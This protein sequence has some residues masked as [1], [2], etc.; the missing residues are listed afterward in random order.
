MSNSSNRSKEYETVHHITSRIAHKVRFLQEEAERNDLIEMIRRA[1]DFTGVKLLGWCIMINHFHILVFLPAPVKVDE[2]EIVRR[3]GVL[4]GAKCA[5]AFEEQLAKL[6]L[7]GEDGCKEVE[8]LLDVQR[9]RM[10]S[11]GEFVKIV[12]QWFSEEYNRRN[13][14][15]GTLW[16]GAYHDRMV[17]CCHK[18]MAACLRYIHLNPIRAAA[19][20][21][22]DGYSWS[23]YSAFKKGDEVAIDGMRFVYS[24]KTEDGQEMSLGEIAEMHEE[25]LANLLEKWKL[26]RAEEIVLNRAAGYEMPDDPLTN[27]AILNQARVHLEEVR[28]ASMDL[29]AQREGEKSA[30]LQRRKLMDE[31]RNLLTLRPGIDTVAMEQALGVPRPSLYRYL[32]KMR[33]LGI[34]RQRERGQWESIK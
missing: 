1:A 11:V 7:G 27:E 24:L 8:R 13:G 17:A 29:R 20:A 9:K 12:K 31:I 26:R 5:A 23:S 16:E 22:F 28:R 21:T 10:Y 32:R 3:Y 19:C 14:H 15:T 6:R 2:K 18:D 34:V 30:R 33:A 25:L 4:K